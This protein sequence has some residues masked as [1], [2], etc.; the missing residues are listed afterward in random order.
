M[1]GGALVDICLLGT[2]L[3]FAWGA[4]QIGGISAL[5]RLFEATVA[6][7]AA[8]VLRDSAGSLMESLLGSSADF[9]RL[10][11]MLLV[12]VGIWFAANRVYR[13]W[14]QRRELSRLTQDEQEG[15][16]LIN[17]DDD[18]RLESVWVARL[19]GAVM[20]MGW[21]VLFIAI[22]VLQPADTPL[23]RSAIAS[24]TGGWLISN[25]TAL[26]WL[27]EGFP[28]Y[29]QTLP[30]GR[31]GAIVGERGSI[32]MRAPL[33][34]EVR[35]KDA[36]QLLQSIN[37]LR[38]NSVQSVFTFN[39]QIAGVARRHAASLIDTQR[40]SYRSATGG[41]LDQRVIAALGDSASVFDDAVGIEVVWAHD[42]ET[43][44]RG[45]LKSDRAQKLLKEP[46]WREIG[47]GVV[48]A[49][50]FNGRIYV[51]LLV[52][53]SE[54]QNG[55]LAELDGQPT[56]EDI[57]GLEQTAEPEAREEAL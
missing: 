44:M 21:G 51:L 5:G 22:L 42:P 1:I 12:G 20:G 26:D 41:V 19:A 4:V 31:I 47:I 37:E 40:L 29:T 53:V 3:A 8:V 45:L 52:G 24:H 13:W 57:A 43:A 10:V 49:G 30:K 28:H 39:P 54:D 56:I 32:A 36:D 6:L 34:A 33:E 38:R 15:L 14:R 18:D 7:I 50:W 35:P 2:V 23:S 46:H 9:A 17:P 55:E 16:E 27:R 48:D 11:G 25:R